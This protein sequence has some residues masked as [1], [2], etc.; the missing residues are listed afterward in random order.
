MANQQLRRERVGMI[1]IDLVTLVGGEAFEVAVVRV[2]RDPLDATAADA[3]VDRACDRRFSGPGSSGNPDRYGRLHPVMPTALPTPPRSRS[4]MGHRRRTCCTWR[5]S[6]FRPPI[7]TDRSASRTA[8]RS[9][10]PVRTSP[11]KE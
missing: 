11:R 9:E 1:E 7:R 10:T 3:V 6:L 5:R 8:D 4:P 2:V